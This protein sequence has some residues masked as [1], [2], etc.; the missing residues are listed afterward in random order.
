MYLNNLFSTE[1]VNTGR[2]VEL[3]VAKAFSII[4]MVFVHVLWFI[5]DFDNILSNTYQLIFS[6]ILGRPCA[7][8]IFMFCMGAGI[9]YSRRS[10]WNTMIKR[11]GTLFLL[12]ILVNV[13]EFVLPYYAHGCLFGHWNVFP[14][15]GGLLLF[16]VDILAFA[17]LTFVLLGIF[18][19]WELSNKQ[20]LVIA[21]VMSIIGSILRF[22]EFGVPVLDLFFGYFIGT[23]EGFTAFPLFNWFIIPVAGYVWGQYFIKAK[24]K[25]QF[26]KYWPIYLIIALIYFVVSTQIPNGFLTN[27]HRY[28]FMTTVDVVFCLMYA[29]ANIGLCYYLSKF[30]P[31]SLIKVFTT[32]SSNIN[33][34]YI[35]QWLFVPL[36]IIFLA[37]VFKGII[38]T[39]LMAALIAIFVLVLSTAC[40]L[41][42]KK[43][44][45]G[46][47]LKS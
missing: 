25:K 36:T 27:I 9:V 22:T 30:M 17:A 45:T 39:D 20:L 4:F 26:F 2:Q 43:L 19:K 7:A 15:D 18:K 32:L 33:N 21:I 47:P 24:N 23:K 6:N 44:R 16:C 31:D 37:Y 34:I 12:G 1:K 5:L 14:L 38:F 8:P 29:H 10:Q 41:Y 35:I 40:A 46:K 28:Y 11:G 13:F 3:D 42:Y